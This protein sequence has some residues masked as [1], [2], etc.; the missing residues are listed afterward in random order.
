MPF[1]AVPLGSGGAT[2]PWSTQTIDF[3]LASNNGYFISSGGTVNATL[4][5]SASVGDRIEI[6]AISGAFTIVQ[7]AG[8][9]VTIG[10]DTTTVGASGSVLSISSGASLSLICKVAGAATGWQADVGVQGTFTIT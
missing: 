4:P 5:S 10:T 7:A 9:Y 6:S 2:L 8:Q 3:T 1:S